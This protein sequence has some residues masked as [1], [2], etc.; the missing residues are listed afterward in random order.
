MHSSGREC[1]QAAFLGLFLPRV[2]CTT[3]EVL[4]TYSQRDLIFPRSQE[5]KA[6]V[7]PLFPTKAS[8]LSLARARYLASD[9]RNSVPTSGKPGA[10]V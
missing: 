3:V 7:K 6:W 8:T 9:S 1:S 10:L 5:P 2:P 4:N